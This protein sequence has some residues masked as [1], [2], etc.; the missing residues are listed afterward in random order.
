MMEASAPE[1]V[2]L[3]NF[4]QSGISLPCVRVERNVHGEQRG[5]TACANAF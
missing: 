5:G 4:C 3:A 2:E 1:T